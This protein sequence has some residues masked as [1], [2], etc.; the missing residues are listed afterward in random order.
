MPWL[1]SNSSVQLGENQYI[2]KQLIGQGAYA[3]VYEANAEG[4]PVVLKVQETDG[5][6]EFYITSE[7]QRRLADSPTVCFFIDL[8]SFLII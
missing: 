1:R 4:H 2:I 3:K 7:L 5:I 6:W 8:F